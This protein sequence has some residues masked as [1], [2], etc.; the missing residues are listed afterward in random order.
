MTWKP[1]YVV[2]KAEG[3]GGSP[4]GE[5]EPCLVIRGQDRLAPF[6]IQAYIDHYKAMRG[7]VADPQVE[8]DLAEHKRE[9]MAW[10]A[11][12]Y[13]KVKWADR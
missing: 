6:M 9:L 12:N 11:R 7:Q 10:Q 8:V 5:D 4:I 1:R 3:I 13:E 2:S